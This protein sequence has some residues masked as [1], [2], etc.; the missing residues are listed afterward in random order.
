MLRNKQNNEILNEFQEN[1]GMDVHENEHFFEFLD[2]FYNIPKS[3][4]FN[5]QEICKEVVIG[6]DIWIVFLKSNKENHYRKG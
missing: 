3:N 6:V 2:E 4:E 5:D 1:H